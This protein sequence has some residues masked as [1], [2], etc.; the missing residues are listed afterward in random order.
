M[1]HLR[2]CWT[3]ATFKRIMIYDETQALHAS[4]MIYLPSHNVISRSQTSFSSHSAVLIFLSLYISPLKSPS[5]QSGA[6][7]K[8]CGIF[9]LFW[10]IALE[11]TKTFSS[12]S[13]TRELLSISGSWQVV[14][15]SADAACSLRVLSHSS[16]SLS[17]PIFF[18]LYVAPFTGERIQYMCIGPGPK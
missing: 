8:P 13:K 14:N 9:S 15:N 7:R 5:V 17:P 12:M 3:S 6:P 2:V 16:L 10:N 18:S 1:Y 4:I 11:D